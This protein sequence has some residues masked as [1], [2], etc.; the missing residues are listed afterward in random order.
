M[1]KEEA[2]SKAK[3]DAQILLDIANQETALVTN[4]VIIYYVIKDLLGPAD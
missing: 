4:L 1:L 2:R 3:A